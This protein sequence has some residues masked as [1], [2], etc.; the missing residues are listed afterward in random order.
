MD[1]EF[2]EPVFKQVL[3]LGK[4]PSWNKFCD[5]VEEHDLAEEV[6]GNQDYEFAKAIFFSIWYWNPLLA[7]DPL[8]CLGLV[9]RTKEFGSFTLN[10]IETIQHL[11][12]VSYGFYSGNPFTEESMEQ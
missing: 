2:Q 3:V 9:S 1:G 6:Y 7:Q 11:Q 12:P 8:S 10:D 4:E 5:F